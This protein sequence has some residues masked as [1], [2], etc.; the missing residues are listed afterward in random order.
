MLIYEEMWLVVYIW[1]NTPNKFI[2][3]IQR[4]IEFPEG[5]DAEGNFDWLHHGIHLTAQL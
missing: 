1:G 3:C 5:T 2:L 4:R